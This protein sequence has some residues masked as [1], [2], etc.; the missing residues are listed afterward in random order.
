MVK[1]SDAAKL[2]LNQAH[3][4]IAMAGSEELARRITRQVVDSVQQ[5]IA[6]PMSGRIGRVVKT[7]ELVLP[8]TPFIVAYSIEQDHIRILAVYHG[9]QRWPEAF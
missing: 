8:R 7:R 9:A 6:F 3:D 1:W 5:L 2:Q 4:Y